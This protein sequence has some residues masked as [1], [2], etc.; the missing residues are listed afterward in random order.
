M[1]DPCQQEQKLHSLE[2]RLTKL[3]NDVY[4]AKCLLQDIHLAVCGNPDLGSRGIVRRL[5]DVEKLVKQ[6]STWGLAI[7]LAI[8][9]VMGKFT[10]FFS[11]ILNRL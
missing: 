10:G 9:L 8:G 6:A 5:G 2:V 4:A 1:T 11:W 3:E 7:V